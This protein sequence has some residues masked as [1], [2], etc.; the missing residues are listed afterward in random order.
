[1]LKDGLGLSDHDR[2]IIINNVNV[3]KKL[4]QIDYN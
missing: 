4:Q 1:M 2:Q 3:S